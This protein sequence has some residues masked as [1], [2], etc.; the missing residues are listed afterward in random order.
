M[1]R[2]NRR[3]ISP[4][5]KIK[6]RRQRVKTWVVGPVRLVL[7]ACLGVGIG[8]GAYQVARFLRTSPA[9]AVRSIEVRGAD[10]TEVSE[11]LRAGRLEEGMNIFAVHADVLRRRIEGLP[12][13]RRV[14]AHRV[15]PDTVVV[16]LQEHI[17]AAVINLDGLYY[18]NLSGEVFKRVQKREGIDLPI[19][20]GITRKRF[21]DDPIRSRIHI[22][23]SLRLARL[24]QAFPCLSRHRLAEVH[25]D[26]LIGPSVILDPGAISIQL[27]DG[28]PEVLSDLCRVFDE[29]D[30]NGIK[31][32][33]ILLDRTG[34]QI[35]ATVRLDQKRMLANSRATNPLKGN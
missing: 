4:E 9:L 25:F 35:K 13:V 27:G 23:E 18:V 24:I 16:Q 5:K 19:L 14:E 2:R 6:R 21:R 17:P 15:I 1:A 33:T 7:L 20:T 34:P 31:A 28:S 29:V 3:K 26:E 32:H 30:R 12:W 11:I 22:K 10:R 8:F